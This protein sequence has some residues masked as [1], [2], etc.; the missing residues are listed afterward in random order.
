[1]MGICFLST[2]ARDKPSAQ[3]VSD[4]IEKSA[5]TAGRLLGVNE[6]DGRYTSRH[7]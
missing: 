7:R 3:I 4:S 5:S 6:R 2:K 1:M